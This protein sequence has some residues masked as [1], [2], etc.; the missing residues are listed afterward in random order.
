LDRLPQLL[1]GKLR[2]ASPRPR[3]VAGLPQVGG[4]FYAYAVRR[5]DRLGRLDGALQGGGDHAA[6][7][8]LAKALPQGSGLLP[9]TLVQSDA[10]GPAGE[11]SRRI[12][13]RPTVTDQQQ[14]RH[15][16]KYDNGLVIVD[17]AKYVDG[18]RQPCGDLSDELEELQNSTHGGFLWI[19]L[20]E[21]EAPEFDLV[22]AELGLHPL[23]VEDVR[24]GRQRAK[25]ER[26]DDTLFV[27]LKTLKYVDATSDI[28]TGELMVFLGQRF[29]VTVRRGDLSPLAKTRHQLEEHPE[30]LRLGPVAAFHAVVDSVVDEYRRI[31]QELANDL[32]AIEAGVFAGDNS[33]HSATIYALK[34]E[35]LE[36]RRAAVPLA[37]P[38]SA[39]AAPGSPLG[40]GEAR[41]LLRDV[42]DHLAQVIDHIE[43]FDRLLTDVLHAHLARVGVSQNEDMRKISAW[44]A[45]AAMP[46]MIAGI[47]GMNF[48]HMP[49]LGW[50]FG[51]PMALGI[52]ALVCLVLHRLFRKSGWL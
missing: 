22:V 26:Y 43:S 15:G 30:L 35:V 34:R 9:A 48:E 16:S 31:D 46:T 47:Y 27:V 18:F 51:Y 25:I 36:F 4:R 23:A 38:L 3:A 8:K 40:E 49:E 28:E 1:F 5:R 39:L 20:K 37:R 14:R 10:R 24:R 21:P 44:V 41:L 11:D 6:Y 52:M 7:G 13:G 2:Q 50:K 45:I 32:E 19:G 29:I 17:Q 33:V 12:G 42:A